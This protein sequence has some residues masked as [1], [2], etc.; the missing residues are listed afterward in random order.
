MENTLE[1]KAK[2]FYDVCFKIQDNTAETFFMEFVKEI[3]ARLE[4]IESERQE[5]NKDEKYRY[6]WLMGHSK[7]IRDLQKEVAGRNG[8]KARIEALEQL[9]KPALFT[10]TEPTV[11]DEA[12]YDDEVPYDKNGK[13]EGGLKRGDVISW[14]DKDFKEKHIGVF[15][16]CEKTEGKMCA[17]GS[18]QHKVGLAGSNCHP[19]FILLNRIT[20][21]FRPELP[22]PKES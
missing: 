20:F 19:D 22:E 15:S 6:D 12:P 5:L 14:K 16:H 9:V 18:W 1:E 3:I 11:K 8:L 13:P 10:V 2:K 21:E 7:D 4:A 17:H